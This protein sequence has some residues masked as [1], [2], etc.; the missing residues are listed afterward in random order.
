MKVHRIL[1]SLS[2]IIFLAACATNGID[3]PDGDQTRQ[4]LLSGE[5]L[6]AD[7]GPLEP[8]AEENVLQ[9]DEDMRRFVATATAGSKSARDKV[10]GL[11]SAVIGSNGL[12]ITYN[13]SASYSAPETFARR[14]AN[15]LSFTLMMVSMLRHVGVD[16]RF[17]DVN[18]PLLSDLR[19]E[20]TLVFYKHINAI[21]QFSEQHR[22]VLDLNMEEYDTTYT[23]VEIDDDSA[24]AQYYNNRAMELLQQGQPRAAFPYLAKAIAL[25]P[26]QS[27][28]WSNLGSLYQRAGKLQ[29][30]RAAF[31]L[32]LSEDHRDL[33]AMSNAARLYATLGDT[34]RAAELSDRVV[35]FRAANPYYRYVLAVN[36]YIHADYNAAREELT[37]AIRLYKEE[38]R[39]HFLLG[40]AYEKLGMREAAEQSMHTALQL[41]TDQKQV[42]R[43]RNKMDRL[44][45]T[46]R[47]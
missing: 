34:K 25:D 16:A 6:V 5:P 17:N 3:G 2:L 13:P 8:V 38:H 42:A 21:V 15:C 26:N 37:E 33:V 28:L 9:L 1:V 40:A 18:V 14:E 43:Y 32:A 29:P 35:R 24:V 46:N 11:L 22:A 20:S 12:G 44:L 7:G 19:D 36:A 27:Y 31:E 41:T 47:Y 4:W 45:T 30:A 10:Q 23:Q 39:F